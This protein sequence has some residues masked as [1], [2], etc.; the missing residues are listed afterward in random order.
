M[1]VNFITGCRNNVCA[2]NTLTLGS[3][4]CSLQVDIKV[5]TPEGVDLRVRNAASVLISESELV[6]KLEQIAC[7]LFKRKSAS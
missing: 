7:H 4:V 2:K 3:E 1:G 5:C 6:F